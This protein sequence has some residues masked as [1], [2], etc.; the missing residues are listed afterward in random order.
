MVSRPPLF[1]FTTQPTTLWP[2]PHL[3]VPLRLDCRSLGGILGS[4]VYRPHNK[5]Y[6]KESLCYGRDCFTKLRFIMFLRESVMQSQKHRP[7][8]R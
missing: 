3:W 4:G 1:A 5:V 2:N 8:T 7:E 6:V